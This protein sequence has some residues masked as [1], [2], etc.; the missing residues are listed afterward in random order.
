MEKRGQRP[1]VF[2]GRVNW[3]CWWIDQGQKR[4][5]PRLTPGMPDRWVW[6]GMQYFYLGLWR[7]VISTG[8][9]F[10]LVLK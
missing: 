10:G 8:L 7:K 6:V 9:A 1:C 5:D 2:T 3:P 4:Q